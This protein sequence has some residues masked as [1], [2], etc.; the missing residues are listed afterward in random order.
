MLAQAWVT[1]AV[2]SVTGA[3]TDGVPSP[4]SKVTVPVG[5]PAPG[6]AAETVAVMS[7]DWPTTAGSGDE[8]TTVAD[9]D[10][11]TMWVSVPTEAVNRSSPL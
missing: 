3:V 10:G 11:C 1:V 2:P 7:T 4:K 5:V 8:L 6:A 9:N